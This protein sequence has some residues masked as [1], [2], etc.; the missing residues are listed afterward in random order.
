MS[1]NAIEKAVNALPPITLEEMDAVKLLNRIDSKYLTSEPV[2]EK[3]LADAASSAAKPISSEEGMDVR[4][5][6]VRP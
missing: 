3:V 2:L 4:F 6:F 1:S 5:F